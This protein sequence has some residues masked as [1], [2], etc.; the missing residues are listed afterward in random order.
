[1]RSL[2]RV[3]Q[4]KGLLK[5]EPIQKTAAPKF[6]LT[7]SGD[8]IDNLMKLCSGLRRSGF[9]KQA[10]ELEGKFIQYKR[11]NSLYNISGEDGEDLVHAAHPNG[12]HKMENIDSDEATFEDILD[13][14]L[15]TLNVVNKQPTGKLASRRF[16]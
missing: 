16:D 14:H 13:K 15:K 4:E 8:L 11:A 10:E 5:D 12:S 1:M 7:P 3:F 9:E 2:V 6:D